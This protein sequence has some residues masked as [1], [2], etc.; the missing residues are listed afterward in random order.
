[1][2]LL[3]MVAKAFLRLKR[4]NPFVKMYALTIPLLYIL[5]NGL[6]HYIRGIFIIPFVVFGNSFF[7]DRDR[8][9]AKE[10]RLVR[11]NSLRVI[12][13]TTPFFHKLAKGLKYCLL[14]S[15]IAKL[16]F[17]LIDA[18]RTIIVLFIYF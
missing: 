10:R 17:N 14:S 16:I 5:P 13:H 15:E 8:R 7:S 3:P 12:Y 4:C 1:M 9:K 2:H 18:I 11:N 6:R